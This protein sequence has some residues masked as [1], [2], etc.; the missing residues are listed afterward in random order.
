MSYA[1]LTAAECAAT[2]CGYPECL[3]RK[4]YIFLSSSLITFFGGLLLILLFR[5]F[6]YV[7]F[8]RSKVEAAPNALQGNTK[9]AGSSS[10]IFKNSDS[11]VGWMTSI[12]DWAA[13]LISAQTISGRILVLVIFLLSVGSVIIYIYQASEPIERCF[14]LAEDVVWQIDL[15]F[16]LVFL[17]YFGLRF[18]AATDRLWFWLELNSL[19]DFFTIPPIFVSIY[20]Q[21]HWLG[22]RFL[23]ALRLMQLPEI[24]QFLTILKT[25]N[26][27]KLANLC[28]TLVSIWLTAAGFIHLVENSGDPWE[29][30]ANAQHMTYWLCVYLLMVTMSTVGYGDV[31]AETTMGRI[32]MTF[33]IMG[34]LAMFASYVP[35]IMEL[36]G[37]RRK[38]GGS[39]SGESGKKHVVLCGHITYE[40]VSNFIK[41]FLHKDRD[42][43]NVEVILLHNAEP[44]LALEAFF[45]RHFTH[46]QFFQGSVLD[47]TDLERVRLKNADACLVL[48]NKYCDDPDQEDA[49]NI[50]RVIS[51]KNYHPKIRT[52]VQLLQYHN[53]AYLL[54]IPS[55]NWREGDDVICLAELKLGLIAQSCLAPGFSTIMANLFA[56]RSNSEAE[57]AEPSNGKGKQ[58]NKDT[59][60]KHYLAGCGN[61]MYTEYLSPAFNGMSF[62]EVSEFCFTKLKL[63]LI[64]VEIGMDTQD[65][66][67]AI[68][69]GR[70]VTIHEGTL[71]FFVAP[72]AQE[73][74]R[75]YYY[76]KNCHGNISDCRKIKQCRCDNV[77]RLPPYNL[78]DKER[79]A[80]SFPSN[81]DRKFN[82]NIS[83]GGSPHK[84]GPRSRSLYHNPRKSMITQRR[85]RSLS[86]T[87]MMPNNT[88]HARPRI[89]GIPHLHIAEEKPDTRRRPSYPPHAPPI[90]EHKE[91]EED[92][93]RFDSTGMFHWCPSRSLEEAVLTR[94]QAQMKIMNGHV[95]VCIFGD[96]DSPLI[97]LRNLVM[98]LRASNIHYNALKHILILGSLEYIK[99]EWESLKNFPKVNVLDG[100]PLSRA[101]LRAVNVNLCDMC[102]ILSANQGKSEDPYLQDKETILASLNLKAMTFDDT[103]G[104]LRASSQGDVHRRRD[105]TPQNGASNMPAAEKTYHQL[106]DSTRSLQALTNTAST[107]N[108]LNHD[109]TEGDLP[110]IDLDSIDLEDENTSEVK[111]ITEKEDSEEKQTEEKEEGFI[112]QGFSPIMG[113]RKSLSRRGSAVGANVP[114]ITEL[115]ND[116]NVQFLD[117]DDDDDPDTELYVTQPFACG[118]AFAVSVLDSLMSATYFNDNAL[119]L[120]RTLITGGATPELEQ[121]L[122]EGA[123]MRG[124]YTTPQLLCN[125]DRC[126]VAQLPVYEGPLSQFSNGGDYG[127]L[128]QYALQKYGILCF[129]IY[130]FRDT[131]ATTATPSSK[132][133]VVTNP[134]FEFVLMPTDLI[135][136]L[137]PFKPAAESSYPRRDRS[138]K[139]KKHE[140]ERESREAHPDEGRPT[141]SS[142]AHAPNTRTKEEWDETL[143]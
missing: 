128:Y 64:A 66:T 103:V 37:G 27:I 89:G 12:K 4:W 140:G 104:L 86:L 6:T 75:A 79:K 7:C 121:I 112:P 133:Y 35:E 57:E 5:L 132:R 28:C 85:S 93:K 141:E 65:S 90:T 129:G 127:E 48:A 81:L 113:S 126:R 36:I 26:S 21:R 143:C 24:M 54:N 11:E 116:S 47:S 111:D 51:I 83:P 123:G 119:T 32:F 87:P 60:Q 96:K 33:F 43:V 100:F 1:N 120:I 30:F 38:Y 14:N 91:L 56:M 42:D 67:I 10:A 84:M 76:C 95:V 92:T 74:K 82:G 73:V 46:L 19:V 115:V 8:R 45:K 72:S 39:Y 118:T 61:E 125:R 3:E 53:K 124:G 137:M 25:S 58:I 34:A 142:P 108:E 109:T 130:R 94:N 78:S 138:S 97:G 105:S 62:P 15:A 23:R 69:P 59:W 107:S 50:M 77:S 131:T 80:L 101:D 49:A 16:N 135:F 2:E 99:K 134:T 41:D 44:D 110:L 17:L 98:P 88:P 106:T 40:S 139:R 63:L 70:S 114:M 122:A 52:I 136:C 22:L 9:G 31:Y 68:N 13:S 117:Q 20:L 71:G 29:Q 55:W 18:I 102:V